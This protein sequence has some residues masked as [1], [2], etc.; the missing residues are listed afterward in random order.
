MAEGKAIRRLHIGKII[1]ALK[2]ANFPFHPAS[3]FLQNQIIAS[4][5]VNR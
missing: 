5:N 1:L 4:Q 2:K 3:D